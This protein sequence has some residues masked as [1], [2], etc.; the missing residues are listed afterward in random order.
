M[1]CPKGDPTAFPNVAEYMSFDLYK[2]IIDELRDLNYTGRI[3]YSDFSEPLVHHNVLEFI[4]SSKKTCPK[5]TVEITTNGDPLTPKKL[6][7]LFNAGL[8]HS[9]ISVYDGPEAQE[10]FE[11]LRGEVGLTD[12]QVIIR[13]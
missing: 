2:K 11:R 13:A 5:M 8:D 3:S 9:K 10:R 7:A 12:K 4:A 6:K 1:F